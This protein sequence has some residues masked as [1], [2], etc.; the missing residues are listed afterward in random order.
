MNGKLIYNRIK[1]K[2]SKEINAEFE[3]LLNTALGVFQDKGAHRQ[4]RFAK[5]L[6]N[7][8]KRRTADNVNIEFSRKDI[9][10]LLMPKKKV[11]TKHSLEIVYFILL[12]LADNDRTPSELKAQNSEYITEI[13]IAVN[14][15]NCILE[16]AEHADSV[17]NLDGEDYIPFESQK[18]RIEYFIKGIPS[19]MKVNEKAA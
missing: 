2:K 9:K 8:A 7:Y 18:E 17:F 5:Y 15:M 3:S 13:Y 19:Y 11:Y 1:G 4:A 16:A 14:R 10:R 6:T 12:Y